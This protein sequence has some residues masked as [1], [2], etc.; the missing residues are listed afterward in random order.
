MTR[1]EFMNRE[2]SQQL[3]FPLED[4]Q[5]AENDE[6][7]SNLPEHLMAVMEGFNLED[8]ITEDEKDT[9]R[10]VCGIFRRAFGLGAHLN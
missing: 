10:R 1:R 7:M 5:D 8:E 9:V 6:Y 4:V 2:I 3:G